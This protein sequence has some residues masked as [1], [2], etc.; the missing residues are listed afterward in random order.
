MREVEGVGERPDG[1][2]NDGKCKFDVK[3]VK[4]AGLGGI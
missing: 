3:Y 4:N 1:G 2:I